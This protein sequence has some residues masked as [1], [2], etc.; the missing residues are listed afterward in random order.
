VKTS[1]SGPK[2]DFWKLKPIMVI[3]GSTSN[4]INHKADGATNKAS[5]LLRGM[6]D[7]FFSIPPGPSLMETGGFK[8]VSSLMELL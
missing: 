8:D 6:P 5:W 4:M 2:A 1:L 7:N 3:S